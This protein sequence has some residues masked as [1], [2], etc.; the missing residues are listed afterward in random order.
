M[1]NQFQLRTGSNWFD[2]STTFIFMPHI[3]FTDD[4]RLVALQKQWRGSQQKPSQKSR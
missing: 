4:F 1:E 2:L 3:Y